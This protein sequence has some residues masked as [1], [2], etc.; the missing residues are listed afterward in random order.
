MKLVEK[1]ISKLGIVDY[2]LFRPSGLPEY[3]QAIQMVGSSLLHNNLAKFIMYDKNYNKMNEQTKAHY[4]KKQ[5]TGLKSRL[6]ERFKELHPL[7]IIKAASKQNETDMHRAIIQAR[8]EGKISPD[9]KTVIDITAE[10]EK[11]IR[12]IIEGLK[13]VPKIYGE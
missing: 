13:N 3:D 8:N 6:T 2:K 9:V 12:Q 7:G 10:E 5:I 11:A 4:L 1:E